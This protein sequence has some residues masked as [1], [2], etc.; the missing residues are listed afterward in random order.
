M[1]ALTAP[2]YKQIVDDVTSRIDSNEYQEGSQLPSRIELA[3]QYGVSHITVQTA[4]RELVHLGYLRSRRGSG[5]F[6]QRRTQRATP[7]QGTLA[8]NSVVVVGTKSTSLYVPH[9]TGWADRVSGGALETV[10]QLGLNQMIVHP[11]RMSVETVDG[12]IADPPSGVVFPDGL[13]PAV[14]AT[15]SR[16][17]VDAGIPV[18]VYGDAPE[19]AAFDRVT[20][21]WESG[22]YFLTRWLIASGRHR[23]IQVW[24]DGSDGYWFAGLR[25]GHVRAME[26]ASLRPNPV[27]KFESDPN[28]DRSPDGFHK[29]IRRAASCLPEHFVAIPPI[30]AIMLAS[31]GYIPGFSA[32]C[33][34]F[35]KTPGEDVAIAG[36]DDYWAGLPEQNYEPCPPVASV[37]KH[38]FALGEQ[39]VRLL[40][41][42]IEGRLADSPQ[43][44]TVAPSVVHYKK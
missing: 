8:Q 4:L 28:W 29:S 25:A 41:D 30:D 5:V 10:F 36:Y 37:D 7:R 18:V 39:L 15:W 14:V 16:R 32:A 44:R 12:L 13:S 26:E 35:G 27:V 33:R 24:P 38:N 40:I 11:S 20:S 6:V 19:L 17:L 43:C 31:D 2:L 21:D 9:D 34:L 42:R 22:A 1:S 3:I 23:I